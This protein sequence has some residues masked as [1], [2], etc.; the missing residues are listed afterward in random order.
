MNAKR[1][2]ASE[3]VARFFKKHADDAQTIT[4]SELADLCDRD[5][6]VVRAYLRAIK[7]R[8]QSQFKNARYAIDSELATKVVDHFDAAKRMTRSS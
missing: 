4:A 5:A 3:R 2:S 1:L 6:K 7:S 8:D